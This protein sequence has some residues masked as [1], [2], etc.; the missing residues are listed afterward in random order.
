MK[1]AALPVL[2]VHWDVAAVEGTN[3][4]QNDRM[5]EEAR[6]VEILSGGFLQVSE[7]RDDKEKEKM[8]YAVN[9]W[10]PIQVPTIYVSSKTLG[11][12]K[13]KQRDLGDRM[14]NR[15]MTFTLRG[16]TQRLKKDPEVPQDSKTFRWLSW[17][18]PS[19]SGKTALLR[20]ALSVKDNDQS[21]TN[22]IVVE[23]WSFTDQDKNLGQQWTQYE[24]W[25]V[26]EVLFCIF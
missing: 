8:N 16:R 26:L 25:V 2:G 24:K 9:A 13:G 15:Q 5:R 23:S 18:D 3:F 1:R 6:A 4:Y 21:R 10:G 12:K 11:E 22:A 20:F 17:F 19:G 7:Y 14:L